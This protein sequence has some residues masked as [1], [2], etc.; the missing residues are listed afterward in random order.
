MQT[1]M[2]NGDMPEKT[3]TKFTATFRCSEITYCRKGK[4]ANISLDIKNDMI[5]INS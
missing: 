3:E 2:L 5:K 1:R 4:E